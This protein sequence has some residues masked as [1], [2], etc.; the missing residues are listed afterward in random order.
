MPT[1]KTRDG[2]EVK[3]DFVEDYARLREAYKR[4][5]HWT[6]DDLSGNAYNHAGNKVILIQVELKER[7]DVDLLEKR[8]GEVVTTPLKVY[9]PEQTAKEYVRKCVAFINEYGEEAFVEIAHINAEI[10][11]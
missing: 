11:P 7:F 3:L 10:R 5:R 6:V 8:D 1:V 4:A 2:R 9:L